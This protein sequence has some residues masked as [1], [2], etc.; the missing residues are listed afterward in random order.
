M[1]IPIHE[2]S[3]NYSAETTHH[4][5]QKQASLLPVFGLLV[6]LTLAAIFVGFTQDGSAKLWLNLAISTVQASVVAY[7]FMDLRH[8][9]RLTWLS[10]GAAGFWTMILFVFTL[11]DYFT[12]HY[13]AH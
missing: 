3:T 12:R 1:S 2:G 8:S 7:Y 13:W 11:T 10:V 4:E 6:C 9:D 5:P